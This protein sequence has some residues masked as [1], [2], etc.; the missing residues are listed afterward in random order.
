M[1]TYGVREINPITDDIKR[2][3]DEAWDNNIHLDWNSPYLKNI[4]RLRLLSD[5]GFPVWDVSYC[6]GV[7]TDGKACRVAL[8]FSQVPKK[9]MY[10]WLRKQ[11]EKA[12]LKLYKVLP[13]GTVSTLC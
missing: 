9:N 3:R 5:P 7:T 1:N 4:T 11:A 10:P 6:Y 8:P 13:M 2:M 12:G